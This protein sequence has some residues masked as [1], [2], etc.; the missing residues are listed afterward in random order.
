MANDHGKYYTRTGIINLKLVQYHFV[1]L[2]RMIPKVQ[3]VKNDKA[4]FCGNSPLEIKEEKYVSE[5]RTWALSA[6]I[7][8]QIF[9]D[10]AADHGEVWD[11]QNR[12]N[13]VDPAAKGKPF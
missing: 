6:Q 11:D 7:A 10:P 4:H 9:D 8:Y 5:A 13:S 2:H 1:L 3:R 12:D